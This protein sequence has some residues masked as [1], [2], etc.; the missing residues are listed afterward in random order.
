MPQQLNLAIEN[1][2]K[3]NHTRYSSPA[4]GRTIG[5]SI[6]PWAE[7]ILTISVEMN[8]RAKELNR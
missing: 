5:N 1:H 2:K 4:P 7:R 6:K 8:K 3:S